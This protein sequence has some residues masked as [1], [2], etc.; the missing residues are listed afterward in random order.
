MR[1]SLVLL[2]A[3]IVLGILGHPA[4]II[5]QSNGSRFDSFPFSADDSS[6]LGRKTI[7]RLEQVRAVTEKYHDLGRAQDDGFPSAMPACMENPPEGGMGLHFVNEDRV[8]TRLDPEHPEILVYA[9]RKGSA[10]ELVGVEYVVPLAEWQEEV[11]PRIFGQS[12]KRSP[13]LGIWYLHVW[14]WRRNAQGL[15]ADWNPAVSC[16]P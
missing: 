10:P 8:D 13:Q 1:N 7:Q 15:F 14:L 9:P 12:L 2:V 5:A 11:P 4:P 3:G 6:H 16:Q